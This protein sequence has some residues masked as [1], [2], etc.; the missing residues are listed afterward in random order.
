VALNKNVPRCIL[1][2][3]T[4]VVLLEDLVNHDGWIIGEMPSLSLAHCHNC[5]L[6]FLEPATSL[7]E[8]WRWYPNSYSA[9]SRKFRLQSYLFGLTQKRSV[10]RLISEYG[11]DVRVLD[12]GGGDGSWC[13]SAT[14]AGLEARNYDPF[15]KHRG[16]IPER[17]EIDV[18]LDDPK[19]DIVR[20]EH[21]LEH[22]LD[23]KSLLSQCKDLLSEGG[24]ILGNTPNFDSWSFNVFKKNWGFLHAPHHRS[25]FSQM[26]L[27]RLARDVGLKVQVSQTRISSCWGHSMENVISRRLSLNRIGHLRIYPILLMIGQLIEFVTTI[28]G[29]YG[30]EVHFVFWKESTH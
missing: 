27:E 9:R 20:L 10:R 14:K 24:V 8:Q 22:A 28:Q 6:A 29:R 13:R 1:C 5:N 15:V 30:S 21:V 16:D 11:I 3:Q 19:Y 17:D 7:E 26:S 25:L 2:G 18:D 23:P 12:F 4:S